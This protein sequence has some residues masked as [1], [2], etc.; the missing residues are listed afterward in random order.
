MDGTVDDNVQIYCHEYNEDKTKTHYFVKFGSELDRDTVRETTISDIRNDGSYYSE[1]NLGRPIFKYRIQPFPNSY[2]QDDAQFSMDLTNAFMYNKYSLTNPEYPKEPYENTNTYLRRSTPSYCMSDI[3]L[4][5]RL[6]L[7]TGNVEQLEMNLENEGSSLLYIE[8]K[9][10][11]GATY[12][13]TESTNPELWNKMRKSMQTWFGE[14]WIP[15]Q[16][17]VTRET[18]K[19]IRLMMVCYI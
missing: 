12:N 19:F 13:I 1:V 16:L 6:R 15:N 3:K 14:Y 11:D 17:Y 7:L 8:D 5:S 9:T 2:Q 4:N 18:I 10:D